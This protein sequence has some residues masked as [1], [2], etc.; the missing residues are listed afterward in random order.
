MAAA[1]RRNHSRRRLAA[2]TFLSNISLDGSHRDT[3][4]VLL[5]RNSVPNNQ[6]SEV[7]P[8]Q[9]ELNQENV[10]TVWNETLNGSCDEST[11]QTRKHNDSPQPAVLPNQVQDRS[12]SSDSEAT[13]ATPSKAAAILSEQQEHNC[14]LL[15]SSHHAS[16]RER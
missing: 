5:P 8:V 4:L 15:L 6:K 13:T 11:E 16:F 2:F 1:I 10:E 9:S 3:R 12:F 14:P 7:Q